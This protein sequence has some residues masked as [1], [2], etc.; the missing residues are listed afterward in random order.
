MGEYI[1]REEHEEFRRNMENEH[2]RASKRIE[3]VEEE[4]KQIYPL[5]TSIERL[6]V[7]VDNI[8]QNQQTYV[9]KVET[10]NNRDG[11]LWRS[12]VSSLVSALAGGF[13]GFIISNLV[14]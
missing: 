7:I 10:L 8:E 2:K 5:V 3:A 13:A 4:T 9:E 12:L 11:N 1:T 14:R 6:A